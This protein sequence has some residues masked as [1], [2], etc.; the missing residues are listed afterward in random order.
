M[1]EHS[2]GWR[3]LKEINLFSSGPVDFKCGPL[4]SFFTVE[5]RIQPSS[6]PLPLCIAHNQL[7]Y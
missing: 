2:Q 3:S 4:A 6:F 7:N 1:N 5:A